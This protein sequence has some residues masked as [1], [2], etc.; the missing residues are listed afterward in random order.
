MFS[1]VLVLVI[2]VDRYNGLYEWVFSKYSR[3][4]KWKSGFLSEHHN[5]TCLRFRGL[6][7]WNLESVPCCWLIHSSLDE[8]SCNIPGYAASNITVIVCNVNWRECGE[9]LLWSVLIYWREWGTPQKVGHD[10]CC[11]HDSEDL[12][13]EILGC[14]ALKWSGWADECVASML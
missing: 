7:L 10:V 1:Y 8:D 13:S 12:E 11:C 5:E 6:G 4:R 3:L 2:S 9:W 14:E